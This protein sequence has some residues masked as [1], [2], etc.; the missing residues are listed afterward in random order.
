MHRDI[1]TIG[2]RRNKR[3]K[4]GIHKIIENYSLLLLTLLIKAAFMSKQEK[5]K[6]LEDARINGEVLKN[7]LRTEYELE[8]IDEK[9]YLRLARDSIEIS[10]MLNGWISYINKS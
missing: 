2:H 1:Y 5:I 6:I 7:I 8:I 10:K 4:L 3:D 9:T